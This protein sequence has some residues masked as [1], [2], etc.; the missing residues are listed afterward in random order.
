MF[1]FGSEV[2]GHHLRRSA[3]VSVGGC[4]G[5][6]G[7]AQFQAFLNGKWREREQIEQLF[8]DF[9][10]AFFHFAC[11]IGVH[12]KVHRFRLADSI[13]DLHQHFIGN[14]GCHGI[15]SNVACG[16][17]SAAVHLAGVLARESAAAVCAASAIGVHND[18]PAGEPGVA[19]RSAN[20]EF[21]G[22][23]H[24]QI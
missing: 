13:T 12:E 19:V 23:I 17:G 7:L 11:A 14:A 18:F 1:V 10:I 4:F 16:I 20:H 6:D 8:R 5:V 9:G 2:F 21:A 24:E 22:R 3:H 15:F